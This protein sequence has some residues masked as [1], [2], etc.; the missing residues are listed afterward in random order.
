LRTS[1]SGHK[2]KVVCLDVPADSLKPALWQPAIRGRPTLVITSPP[3][4]GVNVLYHRWQ[5][6]GR[7][8]TAVPYWIANR[9]DG[10]GLKYYTLGGSSQTGLREYFILIEATFARLRDILADSATVIQL[11][12]FSD[13]EQQ[14]PRYLAAMA[15]AGFREVPYWQGIAPDRIWRQVPSRRWYATAKGGLAS[16]QEILLIHEK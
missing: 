10:H 16:S 2:A 9:L 1:L 13:I 6:G 12:G 5:I 11:I 7:K 8:E 14:L 3:Y 15:G 4:P